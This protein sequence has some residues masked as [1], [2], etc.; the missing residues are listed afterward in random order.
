M[1]MDI[2][3]YKIDVAVTDIVENTFTDFSYMGTYMNKQTPAV[4]VYIVHVQVD[5]WYQTYFKVDKIDAA[6]IR[7]QA[8]QAYTEHQKKLERITALNKEIQA[9]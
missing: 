1:Y 7:E 9:L 4:I 6:V 5:G 2:Q 8:L 3:K